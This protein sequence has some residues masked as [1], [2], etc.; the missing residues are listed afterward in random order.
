[1]VLVK[2]IQCFKKY[3]Y[4]GPVVDQFGF[5]IMSNWRGETYAP[6]KAKA[7]SNL[8]YQY[9]NKFNRSVNTKIELTGKLHSIG[10]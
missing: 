2:E 1:M 3:I 4:E 8:K 7:L 6:S 5:C 10:Y 9:K